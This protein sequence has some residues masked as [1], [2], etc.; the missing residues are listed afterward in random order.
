HSSTN[1]SKNR[2][3]M[4][5]REQNMQQLKNGQQSLKETLE[6]IFQQL[7][8]GDNP[9][10]QKLVESLKQMEMMQYQ[11]QQMQNGQGNTP[12]QQQLLN[13]MNQ[14]LE[15]S[16]RD[17][18]NRNINKSLIDR[19]NT[20]FNKLLELE[21]AEKEQDYDEK[22]ESKQSTDLQN[23]N[24]NELKFNF[25]KFSGKEFLNQPVLNLN[26]FYQNKY[27]EYLQNIE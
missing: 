4:Q 11:L 20:M 7:Q 5:E 3:Q 10:N 16:K 22:R 18:I 1:S 24:N 17:I 14:I 23:K 6:K 19:Q 15:N 27:S 21:N 13:E 26:L 25:K 9:S 2:K 8:K 12:K